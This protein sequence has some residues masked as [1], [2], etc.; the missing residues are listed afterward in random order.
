MVSKWTLVTVGWPPARPRVQTLARFPPA[1]SRPHCLFPTGLWHSCMMPEL[2][3]SGHVCYPLHKPQE[4]PISLMCVIALSHLTRFLF[5]RQKND[6]TNLNLKSRHSTDR[7]KDPPECR[8]SSPM[9]P[10]CH[11][12]PRKL[13]GCRH[14]LGPILPLL[15]AGS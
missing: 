15:E 7:L 4:Q 6:T 2:L 1:R 14:L 8:N 12:S 13:A 3:V 11:S 5:N 9:S 10:T